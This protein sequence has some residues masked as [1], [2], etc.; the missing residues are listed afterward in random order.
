MDLSILPVN[1]INYSQLISK[2]VI[3]P[4][5]IL[6]FNFNVLD[7]DK[8]Y[9][10]KN[11]VFFIFKTFFVRI[12]YNKINLSS[13]KNFIID[14][15][16]KYNDVPYHNFYHATHIL[17]TTYLLINQ[18]DLFNKLNKYILFS[19]L[20][21]ALVHD[22]D[23]PGNNNIFEINT[24]SELAYRYNN[25]SVLE[26][27]HCYL[28]F[29]L[30]KKH[31]LFKNYTYDEFIICRK[32]I[33]NCILGTDMENHKNLIDILKIKKHSGFNLELIEDQYLLAK[34]LVHG[35][36]IGNSILDNVI[37][38]QWGRKIAHELFSQ[39]KKE[40]KKGLKQFSSFNINNDNSFYLNEIKFINYIS[41]PY[42][43]ILSDIFTNL[44]P[45]YE[46]IINNLEIY[47]KKLEETNNL[48]I[49]VNIDKS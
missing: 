21:S 46:K 29:E 33:I 4:E 23:H 30:I 40:Q 24:C 26:Q 42:W 48:H 27:Y 47:N 9:I 10:L 35:A 11:V 19:M 8:K 5:N 6:T 49:N 41:K 34:I 13:F 38:K 1:N 37:C 28:T 45:C 20:I 3:I 12:N 14:V 17:H 44:K 22:I 7:I 36:D 31:K 39:V 2:Y 25:L 15:F 16:N 43:E 18:C 32:T